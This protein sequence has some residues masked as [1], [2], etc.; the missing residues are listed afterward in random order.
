MFLLLVAVG[1]AAG[2]S[3]RYLLGH[4]L[5]RWLPWGTLA[6]NVSGSFLLGMFSG[7][8]LAEPVLALAGVGFCGALTTYSAFAVQS[9]E[10]G[11][12]R[13]SI[14]VALTV[15]PALAGNALGFWLGA[16]A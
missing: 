16:L 13:G 8:G 1:A 5:D 12:G 4:L 15:V 11:L 6:A 14:N 10:H 7:L 3:L 2:S 9:H